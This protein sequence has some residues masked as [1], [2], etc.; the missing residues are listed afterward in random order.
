MKSLSVFL[1]LFFVAGVSNIHA[2]VNQSKVIIDNPKLKVT[3]YNASPGEDV[4]GIGKHSHGPHLT[5]LLTDAEVQVTTA[6]GKKIN[7]KAPAGTTFWS[8]SE[9]HSVINVGKEKLRFQIVE[10]K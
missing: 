9:T 6:D 5:I 2:Q 3:E 7:Q 10:T 1:M 4:C 8:E